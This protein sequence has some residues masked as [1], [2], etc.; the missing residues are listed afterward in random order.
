MN[1][2]FIYENDN[3]NV[4]ESKNTLKLEI[5][6]AST[7]LR[8]Y[9]E[10]SSRRSYNMLSKQKELFSYRILGTEL[11]KHSSDICNEQEE[12]KHA[13]WIEQGKI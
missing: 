9:K 11:E 2:K 12:H 8:R 13:S 3:S 4:G 10:T 7:R 5:A 1:G 6:F